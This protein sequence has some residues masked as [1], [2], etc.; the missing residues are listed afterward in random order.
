MYPLPHSMKA[1]C[2]CL[3]LTLTVGACTTYSAIP[4]VPLRIPHDHI[5]SIERIRVDHISPV[6]FMGAST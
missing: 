6:L 2:A 1:V 3:A 4:P 5:A